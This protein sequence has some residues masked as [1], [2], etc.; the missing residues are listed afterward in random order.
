VWAW[1]FLDRSE[2]AL[3]HARA[4]V[5]TEGSA[6]NRPAL[7]DLGVV[8]YALH[9]LHRDSGEPELLD[10]AATTLRGAVATL[11]GREASPGTV[12]PYVVNLRTVL[13]AGG[14]WGAVADLDARLRNSP[15]DG[16]VLDPSLLMIGHLSPA[17]LVGRSHTWP[18]S[19]GRGGASR[20]RG[21]LVL[22]LVVGATGRVL[23]VEQFGG[24]WR[25]WQLARL[26]YGLDIVP[27]RL[28]GVPVASVLPL[29]VHVT[30]DTIEARAPEG[31]G[32]S[33]RPP[34]VASGGDDEVGATGKGSFMAASVE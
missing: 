10:D 15:A 14:S 13:A 4:G 32:D 16:P 1:L 21:R 2:R 27:A 24:A 6:D 25:G 29:V 20:L 9:R 23:G 3:P 11:K 5:A 7:N 18:R 26:A 34:T 33:L 17:H 22:S 31:W 28:G 19:A 12:D 30:T 8:L